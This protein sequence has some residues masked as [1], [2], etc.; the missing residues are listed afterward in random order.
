M[1]GFARWWLAFLAYMATA[2]TTSCWLATFPDLVEERGAT[3]QNE[4]GRAPHKRRFDI[5]RLAVTKNIEKYIELDGCNGR[6]RQ[7]DYRVGSDCIVGYIKFEVCWLL[8]TP[9]ITERP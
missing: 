8:F 2:A 4:S 5:N 1:Q 9:D 3:D 6:W 7:Q